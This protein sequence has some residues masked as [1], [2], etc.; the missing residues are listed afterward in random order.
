MAGVFFGGLVYFSSFP[1][2][3]SCPSSFNT[4]VRSGEAL[5]ELLAIFWFVMS[6]GFVLGE[7]GLNQEF[8]VKNCTSICNMEIIRARNLQVK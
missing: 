6:N 7:S 2:S 3:L 1:S 4:V 8:A 5:K